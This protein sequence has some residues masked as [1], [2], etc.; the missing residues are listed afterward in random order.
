M[1][2]CSPTAADLLTAGDAVLACVRGEGLVSARTTRLFLD[3][4]AAAEQALGFRRWSTPMGTAYGHTGF[5]G[6]AMAV[7]PDRGLTAV[8][9]TN[10]LHVVGP[11][12]PT[13]P[14]WSAVLTLLCEGVL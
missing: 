7:V 2:A 1:P 10:R 11:P 9:V 5:P 4:G 3:S 13:E 12:V 6:V 14:L 8:L